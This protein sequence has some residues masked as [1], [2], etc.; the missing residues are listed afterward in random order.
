[1]MPLTEPQKI[2]FSKIRSELRVK[3]VG[4]RITSE[5]LNSICDDYGIKH[6]PIFPGAKVLIHDVLSYIVSRGALAAP[7]ET[8]PCPWCHE[9]AVEA[10]WTPRHGWIDLCQHHHAQTSRD[11]ISHL[12]QKLTV[13]ESL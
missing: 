4:E 7:P 6:P 11:V 10:V 1:M 9:P 8:K 5:E 13:K 12:R 2:E 3:G